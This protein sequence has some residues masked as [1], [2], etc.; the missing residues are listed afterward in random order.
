M[1]ADYFTKAL[2]GMIFKQL[3]DMI[4]GNTII[5]LPTDEVTKTVGM[6][7]RIPAVIPPQESRSVLRCNDATR[8]SPRSLTVLPTRKEPMRANMRDAEPTRSSTVIRR[9]A[10]VLNPSKLVTGK[11]AISW[12]EIVSR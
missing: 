4:M 8:S 1:V 9:V 2:Q 6:T 11:R 7:R 12:A 3:R 10:E 5:A